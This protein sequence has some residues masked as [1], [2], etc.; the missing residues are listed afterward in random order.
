M[1]HSTPDDFDSLA[2]SGSESAVPSALEI[3]SSGANR[4]QLAALEHQGLTGARWFYWIAAL[5][6]VNSAIQLGGADRHFV[7]GLGSTQI[8]GA[9]ADAVAQHN[10]A[11]ASIAKGIGFGINCFFAIAV[12]LFGW[13]CT[14]RYTAAFITGMA[15]YFLDGLIFILSFDLLSIGFH[16]FALFCIWSGMSAFRKLNALE[17][18][19]VWNDDPQLAPAVE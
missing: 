6:L 14:R 12:A 16:G 13:L 17:A 2:G 11:I 7:I 4:A 15:L 18:E 19:S 5:S 3:S 8:V 9:I 1:T 10:P